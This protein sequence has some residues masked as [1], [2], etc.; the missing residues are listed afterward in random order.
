MK[1]VVM[2]FI[3]NNMMLIR[4]IIIGA[5]IGYITNW[6]AIKMIFR[7]R[8]P[9]MVFK[10]RIPLTP[11]VVVKNQ[12]R[13]AHA[14]AN[15]VTNVLLPESNIVS[16][17]KSDNMRDEF[18]DGITSSAFDEGFSL[19]DI[20]FVK[21]NRQHISGTASERVAEAIATEIGKANLSGIIKGIAVSS[22]FDS[23]LDNPLVLMALGGNAYDIISKGVA[24]Y[25]DSDGKRLIKDKVQ[26][27]INELIANPVS[28]SFESFGI[29]RNDFRDI[30]C[31][32][33]DGL[34]AENA[35]SM[36]KRIDM[37]KMVE[38]RISNMDV[39]DF[40]A[41]VMS[42]MKKE[43]KSIINLGA[44]LGALIGAINALLK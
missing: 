4:S 9:W 43:L 12:K 18:A 15:A 22:G 14:I 23:F 17:L 35:V 40:E 30:L 29:G 3:A 20:A 31:V 39:A 41:L 34:I 28:Q 44:L 8:K 26:G 2:E 16:M 32:L 42:V 25:L 19:A 24:D 36:L 21:K 5:I 37:N 33:Y 38:D 13:L 7:P 11:G 6:L 1:V 10:V 27:K